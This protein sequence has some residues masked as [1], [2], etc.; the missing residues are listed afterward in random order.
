MRFDPE[1][2]Q[3]RAKTQGG[4]GLFSLRERLDW[5]GGQI[6]ISSA[7]GKGTRL[8]LLAPL[9]EPALPVPAT[10]SAAKG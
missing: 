10:H 5:L 9:A 4:F 8:T 7:P 1:A 6:E 3:T 2:L